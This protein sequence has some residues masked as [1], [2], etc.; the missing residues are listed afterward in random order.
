MTSAWWPSRA[1]NAMCDQDLWLT[2]PPSA[3]PKLLWEPPPCPQPR[4]LCVFG[5]HPAMGLC[6]A[7]VC[8]DP[9]LSCCLPL[10]SLGVPL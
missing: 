9:L 5:Q 2:Y 3:T 1:V 8:P 6:Q 4:C 10:V 7:D